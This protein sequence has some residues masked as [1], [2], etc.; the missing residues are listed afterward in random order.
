MGWHRLGGGV[1][2]FALGAQASADLVYFEWSTAAGG[3]GHRYA[4]TTLRGS[5]DE[6]EAEAV[7]AGGRLASI[8]S[9]AENAFILSIIPSSLGGP[10]N[11]CWI[12]LSRTAAGGWTWSDGS[13]FEYSN[14]NGGEPNNATGQEFWGWIYGPHGNPNSDGRWNDHNQW[15]YDLPGVIEIVPSPGLLPAAVIAGVIRRRRR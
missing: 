13:A 10:G 12:G 2:L 5:W 4:L 1:A 11:A 8:T 15:D 6:M 7:A 9:A 14:W 3:N